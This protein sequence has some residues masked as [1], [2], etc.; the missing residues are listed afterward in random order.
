MWFYTA[1]LTSILSA[2]TVILS[3]KLLKGVSPS[4]LTW[5]TLV[6]A[7]PIILAFTIKD[8]FPTLN[9]LFFVGVCGSVFFYTI[10]HVIGYRAIGTTDLSLIY[11]LVSL[12]PIFT[13]IVALFPPLSEKP[14]LISVSG[15]LVTLFGSYILNAR[16]SKESLIKP[17]KI[18]FENKASLLM[19][20]SVLLDSIVI[21]FD[22][23]A[24]N[25]TLPKNTTFTLLAEN[26]LVIFGL[27]PILFFRN[28]HFLTQVFSNSKM[29]LLLGI[30]NAIFTILA[31][32]AVGGGD[33]GVVAT[34]LKAQILFVLLFGFIFFKDKP[35]I[36]TVFGTAVMIIGVVIIKLGS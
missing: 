5:I 6:L 15:V 32:S 34:I 30:L 20:F 14:T 13:L 31:F 4:V 23:I 27:L 28:K 10:S 9:L 29:L 16:S 2:F 35:K 26:L 7:T 3:K 11:P 1:L 8:G 36:E 17:F 21:I 33:V 25:N 19:I 24:I 12:G 22:K 18:L